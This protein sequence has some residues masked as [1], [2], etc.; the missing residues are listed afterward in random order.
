MDIQHLKYKNDLNIDSFIHMLDDTTECYKFYW[1]DALLKLFSL[2][3]T[4]IVFDDLINQMIADAW[5]SVVEYHLH[6]GPK[7]ASGKIMNSLERAVIKLSQLTN[8]PNDAD[9]DTIILAVKE[10]LESQAK[11]EYGLE[12]SKL[13]EEVQKK[14]LLEQKKLYYEQ[15]LTE[16]LHDT[17]DMPRLKQY[18]QA[19]EDM[20]ICIREQQH[21]IKQQEEKVA[22]ARKKLDDA[23]KERK[24]YEKLKERAFEEFKLELN[25]AEQ[26]EVDELVSFRHGSKIES[27]D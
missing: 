21:I 27:E 8:I 14:I 4:E 1:L 11:A 26:K 19:V 13:R 10:K 20:K 9:R 5:Y 2:G 17:L 15:Q 22:K 16:C 7:N 25:A 12:I 23:M 3:K 24:T 6:L 18:E